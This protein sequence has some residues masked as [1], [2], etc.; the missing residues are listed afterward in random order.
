MTAKSV[1]DILGALQDVL[2]A[3]QTTATTHEAYAT[4]VTLSELDDAWHPGVPRLKGIARSW[5]DARKVRPGVS[6]ILSGPVGVGKTHIAR[7]LLWTV[8]LCDEQGT[9]VVPLGVF[10]NASDAMALLSED[11]ALRSRIPKTCPMVV[12]DDVGTEQNIPYI[13]AAEQAS[14]IQRRYERILNHCAAQ[15][16]S[17]ILTTNLTLEQLQTHMGPRAWDRLLM[18]VSSGYA[19]QLP[20]MPSYRQRLGGRA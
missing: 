18:L 6:L 10:L 20:D 5:N 13:S 12:I 15:D 17:L 3:P 19:V 16:T 2:Q 7:A 4:R 1:G 9:P 14:E 11:G 8:V